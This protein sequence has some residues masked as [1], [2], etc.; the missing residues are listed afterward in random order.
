MPGNRL[1]FRNWFRSQDLG[2]SQHQ[3]PATVSGDGSGSGARCSS[4]GLF[5]MEHGTVPGTDPE[6]LELVL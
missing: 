1:G 2:P 3:E 5:L 4:L 6:T